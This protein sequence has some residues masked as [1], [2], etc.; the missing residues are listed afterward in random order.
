VQAVETHTMTIPDVGRCLGSGKPPRE[1]TEEM[2]VS[3]TSGLCVACSARFELEDGRLV[4]HA[5]AREDERERPNP[6]S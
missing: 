5:S 3:G 1:G 2:E 4:E 6:Y